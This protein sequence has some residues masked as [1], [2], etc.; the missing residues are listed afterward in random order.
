MDAFIHNGN[1]AK[2]HIAS[3]FLSFGANGVSMF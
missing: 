1:V 2:E 3:K